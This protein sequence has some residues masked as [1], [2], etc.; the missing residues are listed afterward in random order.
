M[1][2]G[3]F[4]VSAN[5]TAGSSGAASPA[6]ASVRASRRDTPFSDTRDRLAEKQDSAVR[7]TPPL[8]G[9]DA[10]RCWKAWDTVTKPAVSIARGLP[11]AGV[12]TA[13][14]AQDLAGHEGRMLEIE[15]RL[16]DIADLAHAA[17]RVE[18]G[19]RLVGRLGVHRCLDDAGGDRVDAHAAA[20][21]L[22]GEGARHRVERALG[23]RGERGWHPGDRLVD[24][25]RCDR[26]NVARAMLQ[27]L[28]DGALRDV[29]EA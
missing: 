8:D 1:G 23:Q 28:G 13:V 16:D 9:D 15:D 27:H 25:S 24:Q 19:E 22:D 2:L 18:L 6:A 3:S 4:L 26:D 11:T 7:H 5:E 14:D 29:E 21:E 12:L 10:G 17:N 20:G